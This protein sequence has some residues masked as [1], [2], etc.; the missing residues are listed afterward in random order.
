M[1]AAWATQAAGL[2]PLEPDPTVAKRTLMGVATPGIAPLNP[3]VP[4][5]ALTPVPSE[6]PAL[7]VAT[8][9]RVRGANILLGA[10]ALLLL[11][12]GVF[13]ALWTPKPPLSAQV[14]IDAQGRE[15]LEVTCADCPP[16]SS[17]RVGDERATFQGQTVLLEL[18]EPLNLGPNALTVEL[19]RSGIGRNETLVLEVPV[20]FRIAQDASQLGAD[21]PRLG[22][23]ISASPGTQVE[24]D[25][26]PLVLQAGKGQFNY[27]PADALVGLSSEVR[28]VERELSYRVLPPNEPP[29]QGTFTL[30]A[31][32]A[33]LSLEAPGPSIVTDVER[34]VMSGA[35]AAGGRVQ[36]S[37]RPLSVEANGHF[38]Q[39]MSI[40]AIGETTIVVRAD[41]A[42]HLPRMVHVDVKRVRDLAVEAERY[43]SGAKTD[44]AEIVRAAEERKAEPVALAGKVEQVRVA[45]HSTALLLAVERGCPSQT[46]WARIVFQQRSPVAQGAYVE[47][48][49]TVR[50]TVAGPAESPPIP[51]LHAA[52]LVPRDRSAPIQAPAQAPAAT[53]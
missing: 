53:K 12:L 46:C 20:H 34:F 45:G 6:D 44:Y 23:V 25:G 11:S 47:A 7:V 30:R 10:A 3:G 38:T 40:D 37:G 27:E 52:F 50:G 42:D 1:E 17:V 22:V 51:E 4:K 9:S 48:L 35:T 26:Q 24:I 2:S 36:V 43:R 31:P 8:Q 32:I 14:R 49:G 41:A 18:A 16:G 33:P 13:W 15:T 39:L 29:R 19:E 21:V 5:A 28:T